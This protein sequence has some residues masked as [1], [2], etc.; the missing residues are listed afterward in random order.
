MSLTAFTITSYSSPKSTSLMQLQFK[1]R[2]G[3]VL[4][5]E[6]LFTKQGKG[7]VSTSKLP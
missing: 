3:S 1:R 6:W 7:R 5:M 2:D 4:L